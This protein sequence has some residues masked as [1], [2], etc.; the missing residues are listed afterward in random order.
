MIIPYARN[1]KFHGLYFKHS[2]RKYTND[3]KR[4]KLDEELFMETLISFQ[5]WDF[6]SIHKT[7]KFTIFWLV[8]I[9][10]LI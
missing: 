5:D 4:K 3:W 2:L 10:R 8:H 1:S 6:Y 7:E 9:I